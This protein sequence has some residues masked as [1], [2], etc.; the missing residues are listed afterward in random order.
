MN[1]NLNLKVELIRRFGSQVEAAKC[2]FRTI[3]AG[4][5]GAFRPPPY[6]G[7]IRSC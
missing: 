4:H 1:A 3:P 2:V 5:L 6:R 7:L